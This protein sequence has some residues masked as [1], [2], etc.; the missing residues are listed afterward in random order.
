MD[1]EDKKLII[2][3][4]RVLE[5]FYNSRID[6]EYVDIGHFPVECF[7][8]CGNM[9]LEHNEAYNILFPKGELTW[10]DF[11][12]SLLYKKPLDLI[13]II[14][15]LFIYMKEVYNSETSPKKCITLL[16]NEIN[17]SWIEISD[18]IH[19]TNPI[20]HLKFL[21]V[22]NMCMGIK[23]SPL[24]LVAHNQSELQVELLVGCI[25]Q[26]PMLRNNKTALAKESGLNKATIN[27]LL[28]IVHD[29]VKPRDPNNSSKNIVLDKH[30][31]KALE[32]KFKE[33]TEK[34]KQQMSQ[35]SRGA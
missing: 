8:Y 17:Q 11:S 25:L 35:N 28:P 34:L 24:K 2:D 27:R 6:P 7:F 20:A 16:W 23:A 12:T 21:I 3:K 9:I 31:M 30:I 26:Y 22:S 33:K 15:A 13:P 18:D 29:R 4:T 5:D 10:N 32:K 14:E 1:D 19:D